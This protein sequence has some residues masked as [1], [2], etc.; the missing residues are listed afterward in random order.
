M[1]EHILLR[2]GSHNHDT[3][4][5]SQHLSILHSLIYL[6]WSNKSHQNK[7]GNKNDVVK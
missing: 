7:V 5:Q 6:I 2:S 1:P 3:K 4:A